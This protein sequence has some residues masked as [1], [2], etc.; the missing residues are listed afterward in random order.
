MSDDDL[1]TQE[2]AA[3]A[4]LKRLCEK[5]PMTLT[6]ASMDGSL[7]VIRHDHPDWI[8][9]TDDRQ[10]AIVAEDFKHIPNTGGGW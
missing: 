5:W 6:L 2:R 9:Q 10:D 3:I 1:T 8:D 4:A 7:Y